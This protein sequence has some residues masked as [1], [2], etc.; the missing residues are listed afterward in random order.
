MESNTITTNTLIRVLVIIIATEMLALAGI[1]LTTL[2]Y[3]VV[4][5]GLR[6]FQIAAILWAVIRW[7]NGLTSIKWAPADWPT[8]IKK[9]AIWSMGFAMAAGAGVAVAFIAGYTPLHW[10]RSPMPAELLDRTLFFIVGGLIAPIAEE[11]CFRGVIYTYMRDI[12]IRIS[13]M[14][15]PKHTITGRGLRW[16]KTAAVVFAITSSTAVF[17]LLHT[18]HG[19]PVTQIVGGVVFAIAYETT[20]NLMTP[21]VIHS[22]GNLALFTISII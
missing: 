15:S 9:G 7:E 5:G 11:I 20:R 18:F 1:K 2:P 8:G 17:T 21:I 6:V 19:I 22:L 14:L 4:L 12:G 10:L 3:M 13:A 16:L